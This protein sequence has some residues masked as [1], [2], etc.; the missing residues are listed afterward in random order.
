MKY[1]IDKLT[2]LEIVKATVSGTLT[3][4]ERKELYSKA[5]SELN[6]NGYHRLLI[7]A[8]GS[9]VPSNY[10]KVNLLDLINNMRD[11]ETENHTK[12]ALLS[13]QTEAAHDNFVKLAQ[14]VG[15]KHIKH[16]RNYDEAIT[17]LLEGKDIFT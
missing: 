1:V 3:Q 4:D 5:V 8:T 7:D 11:H 15:R 13:T 2:D 6:T 16:F 9:K 14:I 12:I 17:W 10:T